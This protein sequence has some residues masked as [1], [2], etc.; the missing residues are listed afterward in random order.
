MLTFVVQ[1]GRWY[2]KTV[3]V[4]NMVTLNTKLRFSHIIAARLCLD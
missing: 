1:N 4:I 2:G 3:Y